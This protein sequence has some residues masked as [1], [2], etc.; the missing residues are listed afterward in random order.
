MAYT[1]AQKRAT[2]KW[3]LNNKEYCNSKTN[4]YTKKWYQINK[5][6]IC[7]KK[8]NDYAIKKLKNLNEQLELDIETLQD[9]LNN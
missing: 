5:E 9:K 6:L 8:R 2:I 1:E 4:E 3:R 7:E